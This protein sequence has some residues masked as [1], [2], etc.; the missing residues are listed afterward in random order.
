MDSFLVSG[1]KVI[2]GL[3]V[4]GGIAIAIFTS[5]YVIPDVP[6]LLLT[7]VHRL[8][9]TLVQRHIRKLEG[10]PPEVDELA[11]EAIEDY[12]EDEPLLRSTSPNS[13]NRA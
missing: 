11:A 1:T 8:I 9:Y 13:F 5:W 10:I 3:L 12:G 6:W 2:N 7:S 4:A